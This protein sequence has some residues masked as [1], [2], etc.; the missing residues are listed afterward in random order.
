MWPRKF[1]AHSSHSYLVLAGDLNS[2]FSRNN[3]F[4]N[5][6]RNYFEDKRLKILWLDNDD[7]IQPVDF[8]HYSEVNGKASFS[9]ID[10]FITDSNGF[11]AIIDAGAI[12]SGLNI[13]INYE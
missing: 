13:S 6:T 5:M 12:H 1:D 4:T 8:T 2:D 9:T 7:K 3:G 11:S 10:H